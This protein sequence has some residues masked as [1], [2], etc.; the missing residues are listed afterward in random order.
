MKKD[1]IQPVPK[2][3]YKFTGWAIFNWGHSLD[4]VFR[5]RKDAMDK[6]T[7]FYDEPWNKC[8]KYMKV[9]KVECFV[10]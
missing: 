6:C 7:E 10:V 3:G 8:K 4:K 1:Y 5:T 9:V 2:Q